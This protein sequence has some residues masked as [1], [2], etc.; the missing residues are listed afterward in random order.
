MQNAMQQA[1]K[2]RNSISPLSIASSLTHSETEI[3][4]SYVAICLL[5]HNIGSETIEDYK[6]Y[7]N[8]DAV[9]LDLQDTNIKNIVGINPNI[10]KS[11]ILFVIGFYV[12][13]N[14]ST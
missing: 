1:L 6:L 10:F 13:K 12:W 9:V 8:F 11:Q 4:L 7:F 3:N 2:F 14:D 5:I